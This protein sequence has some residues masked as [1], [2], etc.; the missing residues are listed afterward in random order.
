MNQTWLLQVADIAAYDTFRCGSKPV[1]ILAAKN[2]SA[3]KNSITKSNSIRSLNKALPG[4][5]LH[6]SPT[7]LNSRCRTEFLPSGFFIAFVY[8]PFRIED[9]LEFNRTL[10]DDS[11]EWVIVSASLLSVT[12][13]KF[14]GF[15]LLFYTKIPFLSFG[16]VSPS[17][18]QQPHPPLTPLATLIWSCLCYRFLQ[19]T[20]HEGV[21]FCSK[22]GALFL[23]QI[24]KW[25]SKVSASFGLLLFV[26]HCVIL[27]DWVL[28]TL[29]C[30]WFYRM[31]FFY[32]CVGVI[33]WICSVNFFKEK[34][35][36]SFP[37]RF[38]QVFPF[39]SLLFSNHYPFRRKVYFLLSTL[40]ES[41]QP[42][43]C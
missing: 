14:L 3:L 25:Y 26:Y 4:Q 28:N 5:L 29:F 16:Y 13:L 18:T 19:K 23:R 42:G 24:R 33:S 11:Y 40:F 41:R 35:S 36:V 21:F 9:W 30:R 12:W 15:F 10:G 32:I 6:W 7:K 22:Q 38:L 2:I 8:G 39:L 17:S 20:Q 37:S 31:P 1:V 27:L 34:W 43:T